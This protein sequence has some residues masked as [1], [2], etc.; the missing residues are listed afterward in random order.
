MALIVAALILPGG[1]V[2]LAGTALFHALS[3][4]ERGRKAL[5]RVQEIFRRPAQAPAPLRQAA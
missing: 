3:R 5:G 1:L 4:T 2:A